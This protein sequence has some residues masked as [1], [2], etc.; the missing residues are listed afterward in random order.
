MNINTRRIITLTSKHEHLQQ[1]DQCKKN[2]TTNAR[3][4]T[5]NH[6]TLEMTSVHG[7]GA[8]MNEPLVYYK[9]SLFKK[10][11]NKGICC[12]LE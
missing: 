9:L 7:L 3:R 1:K 12:V 5:L 8:R 11:Q 6:L 10:V 2:S 4:A